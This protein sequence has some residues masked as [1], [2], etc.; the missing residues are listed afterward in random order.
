MIEDAKGQLKYEV[1]VRKRPGLARRL[2]PG[3]EELRWV[4]NSATLIYGERDAVLV[5]AFLTIEQSNALVEWIA[6]S[7]K[8]LTTIYITHA[9]GDH[10]FSLGML[11]D[12][13]PNAKA[14]ATPEV[15]TAMLNQITPEFLKDF[16]E[17]RFPQQIPGRLTGAQ[18]LDG[19]EI[20]LEGESLAV[21]KLGHTDTDNSTCVYVPSLALVVAGDAVY[22][23]I[24]PFQAETNDRNRPEWFAALDKIDALHP[25]AV[26]AGHKVPGADDSPDNV[27]R[28]RQYL[29]DFSR[30]QQSTKTAIEL[31]DR[32]L[33]LYPERANPGSLWEAA[34][35]AKGHPHADPPNP[36]APMQL[37]RRLRV[38]RRRR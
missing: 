4:A 17:P 2:P 9:H 29:L 25:Q 23:G 22:N 35:A 30:L 24:H 8:N 32:M 15:C 7:G 1:L 3:K 20:A 38:V 11:L 21:I 12:R 27:A 26:I 16:W 36:F 13:F 33:D 10:F 31:Y 34:V 37:R 6:A 28:T 18:P 19:S 5:D 14:V